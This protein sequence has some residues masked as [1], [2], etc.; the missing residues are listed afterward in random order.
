MARLCAGGIHALTHDGVRGDCSNAVDFDDLLS[1][2]NAV[3]LDDTVAREVSQR[4]RH[5]LVDEFQDTN[6]AQYA[7]VH[8]LAEAGVRP[9]IPPSH[10][11]CFGTCQAGTSGSV[12]PISDSM[13]H[14]GSSI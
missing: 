6:E 10:P 3:L 7:F 1:L 9:H 8:K 11:I 14:M 4:H 12:Q 5:I 13:P 2:A